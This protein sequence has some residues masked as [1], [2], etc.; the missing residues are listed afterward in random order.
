MKG[1]MSAEAVSP[2]HAHTGINFSDMLLNRLQGVGLL[3]LV[4]AGQV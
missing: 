4:P 2:M 1:T 3:Q